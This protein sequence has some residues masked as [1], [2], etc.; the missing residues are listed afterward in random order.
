MPALSLFHGDGEA[1]GDAFVSSD[2]A[3][4]KG[5]VVFFSAGVTVALFSEP[6]GGSIAFSVEPGAALSP[7]VTCNEKRPGAG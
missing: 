6:L 5:S 2:S 1:D 3:P 7:V 4:A